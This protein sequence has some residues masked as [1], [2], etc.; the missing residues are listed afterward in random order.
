MSVDL[1]A[2]VK[3]LREVAKEAQTPSRGTTVMSREQWS[4]SI[5]LS[6]SA[7]ERFTPENSPYRKQVLLAAKP[8]VNGHVVAEMNGILAAL[9]SDFEHG[10]AHSFEELIHADTAG[11]YMAQAETLHKSGYKDA[12][13]VL[14]GSVL[15]QHLRHL[16]AKHGIGVTAGGTYKRAD[17]LN[18]ELTKASAYGKAEQKSVTAWLARRND[19]AHGNYDAYDHRDVHAAMEGIQAFVLRFPA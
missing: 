16:A 2:A 1:N 13:M 11:D 15:E 18:A 3:E 8:G 19:A 5:A 6:R 7:V 14:A 4:H 9:I 12:A 17:T 10:R